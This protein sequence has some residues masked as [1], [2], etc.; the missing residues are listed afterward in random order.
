MILYDA[1]GFEDVQNNREARR[2]MTIY[3]YLADTTT[4]LVSVS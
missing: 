3:N 2:F 4:T 1:D